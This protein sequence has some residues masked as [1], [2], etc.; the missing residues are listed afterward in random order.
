VIG[1][2]IATLALLKKG[3]KVWSEVA[4][5]NLIFISTTGLHMQFARV[6]SFFRY[7]AYLVALGVVVLGIA[8]NRT[9]LKVSALESRRNRIL[10]LVIA[11]LAMVLAASP[12]VGRAVL[13]LTMI[14]QAAA[15]IYEQQYQMG[16]FLREFC[17]GRGVAVNDIAAVNFLADIRCLDLRGLAD[18]RTAAARRSGSFNPRWLYEL[19]K[20]EQIEIAIIYTKWY[21]EYGGLPPQWEE[22]GCWTIKNN[23][24]T[25]GATVSFYAVDPGAR[26]ALISSLR[27]FSSKLPKSVAQGGVYLANGV[28]H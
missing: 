22:V 13:S 6:R 16:L 15:N 3:E 24:V 9:G 25:G 2:L 5:L 11:A 27:S 12:L 4:I 8:L 19:A 1:S 7:E 26:D 17:Q 20:T 14:R 21:D 10:G 28:R 18:L 23:V